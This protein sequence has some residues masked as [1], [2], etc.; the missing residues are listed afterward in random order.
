MQADTFPFLPSG[1]CQTE[2]KQRGVCEPRDPV[3]AAV[4]E[5]RHQQVSLIKRADVGE[6][7]VT[8]PSR[9]QGL[10]P[11]TL[12][13]RKMSAQPEAL[14]DTHNYKSDVF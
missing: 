9:P 2:V 8:A 14:L 6:S 3:A 1:Q 12:Y 11:S 13:R 4:P 5:E 10:S 7:S